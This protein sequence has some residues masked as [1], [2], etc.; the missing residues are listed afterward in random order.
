MKISG[1]YTV[2]FFSS[3]NLKKF[4]FDHQS[5]MIRMQMWDQPD[6]SVHLNFPKITVPAINII[7][8]DTSLWTTVPGNR[9]TS[10]KEIV[11]HSTGQFTTLVNKIHVMR[12]AASYIISFILPVNLIAV[13]SVFGYWMDPRCV[14]FLPL[15][16]IARLI[17]TCIC[18]IIFSGG[19]GRDE[20]CI[21]SYLA[22]IVFQ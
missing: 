18:L 16:L 7:S 14:T 12:G 20:I 11:K 8:A 3:F 21:T 6:E 4:P 22:L 19:I 9:T 10:Y 5:Y 15:F 17:R 13:V 2:K 1:F